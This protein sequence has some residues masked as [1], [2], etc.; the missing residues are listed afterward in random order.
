MKGNNQLV[1]EFIKKSG[2]KVVLLVVVALVVINK[3]FSFSLN[4]QSPTREQAPKQPY[5]APQQPQGQI[6]ENKITEKHQEKISS[7]KEPSKSSIINAAPKSN[8]SAFEQ[9]KAVDKKMRESYI[10]R[11]SHV[12]VDEMKKFKIPASIVLAQAL[13]NSAAGT[14]QVALQGKNHFNLS[15]ENWSGDAVNFSDGT[16]Y[17]EF[18]SPWRSYRNHS[19]IIT[20][21][22][23]KH[24]KS[25][26]TNDYKRWAFGIEKGG[27]S[28]EKKYAKQLVNTIELYNLNRFDL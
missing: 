9:L 4:L 11:F 2:L 1:L 16:C 22:N 15:C 7:N 3:D 8:K 19:K 10:R 14:N 6:K 26:G 27:F 13:L 20:T 18:V 25:L 23:Y 21:G 28:K 12:A 24:L 5:V 17:R